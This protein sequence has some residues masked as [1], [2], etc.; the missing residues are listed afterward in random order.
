MPRLRHAR[1]MPPPMPRYADADAERLR[2]LRWYADADADAYWCLMP[3]CQ[4]L[5]LMPDTPF[6]PLDAAAIAP[7][8]RCHWLMPFRL[9]RQRGRYAITDWLD[10]YAIFRWLRRH[11]TPSFCLLSPGSDY[12]RHDAFSMLMSLMLTDANIRLMAAFSG[13]IFLHYAISSLR[14]RQYQLG[15]ICHCY[16]RRAMYI[17]AIGRHRLMPLLRLLMP[18]RLRRC[19]HFCL[20]SDYLRHFLWLCL[21]HYAFTIT[22]TDYHRHAFH[23]LLAALLSFISSL[24]MPRLI[25]VSSFSPLLFL[26][27]HFFAIIAHALSMVISWCFDAIC[28]YF[29]FDWHFHFLVYQLILFVD[30]LSFSH[31]FM[32]MACIIITFQSS[33]VA[34]IIIIDILLTSLFIIIIDTSS[35]PSWKRGSFTPSWHIAD[36]YWYY[37][38]RHFTLATLRHFIF[39]HI[40]TPCRLFHFIISFTYTPFIIYQQMNDINTANGIIMNEEWIPNRMK[41]QQQKPC[42]NHKISL[43]RGCN[44]R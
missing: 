13:P 33:S 20:F 4:F 9:M 32:L 10:C 35:F 36:I 31:Y 24:M 16:L 7:Y 39:R 28:R 38:L 23:W 21:L 14:R 29:F 43:Q 40:I 42:Q 37:R 22:P 1:L 8:A 5:L 41:F 15:S 3:P 44:E 25:I 6:T 17:F 26:Y 30:G 12:F 2:R 19:R 18:P 11:F 34:F 27:W